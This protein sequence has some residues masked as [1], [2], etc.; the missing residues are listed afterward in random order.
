MEVK[1]KKQAPPK[2]MRWPEDQWN[3]VGV[4]AKS[5]G[6]SRSAFV[7]NAALTAA[8]ATAAELPPYSVAVAKSTPQNTRP[9]H[10]DHSIAQQRSGRSGG[11]GSRSRSKPE[12][13]SGPIT[14]ELERKGGDFSPNE[15]KPKANKAK[16]LRS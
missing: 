6:M 5:L 10:F 12:A 14:E 16:A 7:R 2:P 1:K 4:V 3:F 9:N 13:F 15:A 11:G 8:K